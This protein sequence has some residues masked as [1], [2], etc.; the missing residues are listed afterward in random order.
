MCYGRRVRSEG[1]SLE[2]GRDRQGRQ[3]DGPSLSQLKGCEAVSCLRETKEQKR[4]CSS[5]PAGLLFSFVLSLPLSHECRSVQGLACFAVQPLQP[6]SNVGRAGYIRAGLTF[7]VARSWRG[8]LLSSSARVG[9]RR[10]RRHVNGTQ[11]T[12]RGRLWVS[13]TRLS[14]LCGSRDGRQAFGWLAVGNLVRA[15]GAGKEDNERKQRPRGSCVQFVEEGRAKSHSS[16][17][18]VIQIIHLLT[19]LEG[20]KFAMVLRHD[21]QGICHFMHQPPF[22]RMQSSPVCHGGYCVIAR[23][24]GSS[25]WR[26]I[27]PSAI[28]RHDQTNASA[29]PT[30]L[31]GE[32]DEMAR[33]WAPALGT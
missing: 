13:S 20:G 23:H 21:Q 14:F 18:S 30:R 1:S 4:P 28:S 2:G 22:V 12:R 19:S 25:A 17:Q 24:A 27:P 33:R 8:R 5:R 3:F 6:G 11:A 15:E 26:F 10:C 9:R 7:S 16:S 31:A 32:I 29:S